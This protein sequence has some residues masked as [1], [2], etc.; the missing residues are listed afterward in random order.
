V[1]PTLFDCKI[2]AGVRQNAGERLVTLLEDILGDDEEESKGT[3]RDVG[4][5]AINST[6][7]VT[8]NRPAAGTNFLAGLY[9]R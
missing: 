3:S 7:Q 5:N 2:T 9:R 6:G 4:G 8:P 1:D